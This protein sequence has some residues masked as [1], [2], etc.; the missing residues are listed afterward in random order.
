ML[1]SIRSVPPLAALAGAFLAACGPANGGVPGS[2]EVVELP[3]TGTIFTIVFENHGVDSVIN[4]DNPYVWELADRYGTA[5]AYLANDHPS[6]PNYIVMTSGSAQG[7]G[8]DGPPSSHP[9]DTRDNLAAQ[10]DAA[11][12]P[13]RAYM[14][15]MG[16]PCRLEDVGEYAV[17]HNPFAYYTSLTSDPERCRERVVDLDANLDADLAADTYRFVWITPDMC[18]DMHD[19]PTTTG[20]EWL[21]DLIPRLMASPGYQR[22]GAIFVTFDEGDTDAS[23]AA[24]YVFGRPQNIPFIVISEALVEPGFISNTRYDHR[25]YLA[26]IE[27]AFGLPR[28]PT[29]VDATPMADFFG[30]AP[31]AAIGVALDEVVP[32]DGGR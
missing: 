25:S 13:W 23:Y 15:G 11:G 12:I 28:L 2:S 21:R 32:A 22:G 18:N 29:T 6:L 4:P 3:I 27:D 24:S 17:K 8:D 16:E 1:R 10:L 20:D 30:A 31:P 19:C 5:E 9:L 7:I 26:T 14:E